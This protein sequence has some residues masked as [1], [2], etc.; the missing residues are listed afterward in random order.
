LFETSITHN[1]ACTNTLHVIRVKEQRVGPRRHIGTSRNSY[2]ERS[3]ESRFVE[4]WEHF[5]GFCRFQVTSHEVSKEL[6]VIVSTIIT[7][8]SR[9]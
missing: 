7:M 6:N 3:F 5:P 2:V 9:E 8:N 1:E 4:T